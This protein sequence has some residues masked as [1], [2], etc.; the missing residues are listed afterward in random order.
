MYILWAAQRRRGIKKLALKL[1]EYY[2]HAGEGRRS[3]HGPDLRPDVA[4]FCVLVVPACVVVVEDRSQ[5]VRITSQRGPHHGSTPGTWCSVNGRTVS[6]FD[7]GDEFV[8][9]FVYRKFRVIVVV[10]DNGYLR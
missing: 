3:R 5:S 9:H 2:P 1:V 7:D 8:V 10:I 4:G 6:I